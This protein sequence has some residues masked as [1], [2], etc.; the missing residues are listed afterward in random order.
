[1]SV[2]SWL[3]IRTTR[4]GGTPTRHSSRAT[5]PRQPS[6]RPRLEALDE[7]VVPSTVLVTRTGDDGHGGTLRWAVEHAHSGD[8]ILLFPNWPQAGP[9]VLTQGEL[10]L[11]K[12]LAIRPYRDDPV[13]I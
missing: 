9:I 10:L 13:T 2:L 5:A 6:F 7:R 12:D 8:T 11:D 4:P 1:M 3:R